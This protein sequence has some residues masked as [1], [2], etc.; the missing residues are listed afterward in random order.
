MQLSITNVN[1]ILK[2]A[3][4]K[5]EDRPA[6]EYKAYMDGFTDLLNLVI[7]EKEADDS[8]SAHYV[9]KPIGQP[10]CV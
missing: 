8:H 5:Y 3:Y 9:R 7:L 4:F 6:E 1:D 2:E 10:R